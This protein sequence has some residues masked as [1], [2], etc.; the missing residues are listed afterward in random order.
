M[1]RQTLAD[2]TTLH[3]APVP[4]YL[5]EQIAGGTKASQRDA[6][7][8]ADF[9]LGR[10][11]KT[12]L[13]VKLKAL[14]II[15][16]C[17][18]EGDAAFANAIREDEGE[19]SAYLQYSGPP[20][21]VMGDERYRRIR[22]AAQEALVCLNDGCLP[23]HSA[24]STGSAWGAPA[25]AAASS[26]GYGQAQ[27]N[28]EPSNPS[29]YGQATSSY[30]SQPWG[31]SSAQS[32]SRPAPYSDNPSG[33]PSYGGQGTGSNA[34]Y[35]GTPGLYGGNDYRNN[36]NAV[37]QYGESHQPQH[38]TSG[39]SSWSTPSASSS[40]SYGGAPK[41]ASGGMWS[42]SGYQKSAPAA[43]SYSSAGSRDTRPTVLVGHTLNFPRA[44]SYG[45]SSLLGGIPSQTSGFASQSSQPHGFGGA[46][47]RTAGT[48]SY[49]ENMNKMLT[50]PTHSSGFSNNA[51]MMHQN[52]PGMNNDSAAVSKLGKTVEGLVKIGVE[53]KE[54]WDRR[55]MDKSIT[56]SLADHDELSA[57]PQIMD[58]GYFQPQSMRQG[59]GGGDTSGE[60]ERGLI[61]NLTSSVGLARAP[62]ADA[63]KRFVELAQ[64]LDYQ[65]IG[66][67]L[68][69]K[70]ED[71]AWQVRL[72]ALHVVL[73][74]LDS[75]GSAPYVEIFEDNAGVFE[76]QSHAPQP[77]PNVFGSPPRAASVP[78]QQQQQASPHVS[79]LDGFDAAPQHPYQQQVHQQHSFQQQRQATYSND[80]LPQSPTQT[81]PPV[82]TGPP[83]QPQYGDLLP[84]SPPSHPTQQGAPVPPMQ[85][86]SSDERAKTLSNFGKDLFAIANSPR[87]AGGA[88]DAL[89]SSSGTGERSAF[90][91][92]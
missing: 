91:F 2:A 1:N 19:I 85:L 33:G 58:R 6:E 32:A 75:P 10:L 37:P 47:S 50:A 8:T 63:L 29:T 55:N 92:M 3:D 23:R 70:L 52:N 14:Q 86:P 76:E 11:G 60:Y 53:A 49:V 5:M 38:Q 80:L 69:D 17:I 34:G 66:D 46:S 24:P 89:A 36:S 72:K 9:L 73:A 61:D 7:K 21:P 54:R 16:F 31:A 18:R 56:S 45:N 12:N 42:S 82:A 28:S 83:A 74:L 44:P 39:L 90:S 64:T 15:A 59:T 71:Q 13:I 51:M 68:L 27:Y 84:F 77:V 26:S 87:N 40:S 30:N 35:G 4:I 62:P 48:P 79:L 81:S 78:P 22:V 67:I 25:P 65:T 57:G 20:D 43:P 88:A 41:G